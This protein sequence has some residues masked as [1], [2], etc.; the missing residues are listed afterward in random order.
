[1]I[2]TEGGA[3]AR[4]FEESMC[5][6]GGASGG[7]IFETKTGDVSGDLGCRDWVILR[8]A[9]SGAALWPRGRRRVEEGAGA[10]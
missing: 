2:G 6:A 5:G 3:A 1:M 9:G 4:R 8:G 10:A 7:D